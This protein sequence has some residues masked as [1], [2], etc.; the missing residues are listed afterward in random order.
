MKH[1]LIA[2]TAFGLGIPVGLFSMR[3]QEA[4]A[5]EPPIVKE[6]SQ[7]IFMHEYPALVT[8]VVDG[9][10]IDV[11]I[12]LGFKIQTKQRLRLARVDTPE[13][14]QP[15]FDEAKQFT[16]SMIK[17]KTVIIRAEKV[18]KYGYYLADVSINGKDVANELIAAKMG[19]PYDG[20][21]KPPIGLVQ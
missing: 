17:N 15:S 4:V 14:N 21:K 1:L 10:T 18:S 6:C 9:D 11:V 3:H 2:I 13:R 16:E 20:G 19:R 12:D 5:Q 8:N 7:D